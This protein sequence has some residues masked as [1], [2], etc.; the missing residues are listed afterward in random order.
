MKVLVVDYK[1]N[2]LGS[3]QSA[4]EA[5]GASVVVSQDPHALEDVDKIVLPGIGAFSDAMKHLNAA[6]WVEALSD[7]VITKKKKLLG[8]C[9]GMQ[10]LAETGS[11]GGINPGLGFIKGTVKKLQAQKNERIPHVGWNE[12]HQIKQHPL[13]AGIPD[14]SDFYFVHSYH[15]DCTETS[16][17]IGVTPYCGSLVSVVQSENVFGMQF[18]P[19]K[20]MPLGLRLVHNFISL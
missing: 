10:L 3:I 13:L 8:I 5:C 11:E 4:L 6:G 16:T 7:H 19:E 15:F 12:V 9:L 14:K 2:N 18:H 17:I 20:S 1:M